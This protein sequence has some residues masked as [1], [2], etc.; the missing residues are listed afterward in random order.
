LKMMEVLAT[1]LGKRRD[2][3]PCESIREGEEVGD[4][5][6]TFMGIG[7][8]LTIRHQ[9][10]SRDTFALGSLRAAKWVKGKRPG[11]YDMFD[12]LGL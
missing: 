9:A 6:A 8:T 7:E 2:D 10:G 12:V 3:I 5:I 11:L 1:S 4:H